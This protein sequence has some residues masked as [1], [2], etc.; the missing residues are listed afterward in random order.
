MTRYTDDDADE[1]RLQAEIDEELA[2][3]GRARAI[4][5]AEIA[6]LTAEQATLG[7]HP[8]HICYLYGGTYASRGMTA[9]NILPLTGFY[10]LPVGEALDRLTSVVTSDGQGDDLLAAVRTVC[11]SDYG[12]ERAGFDWLTDQGL[13]NGKTVDRYWITKPKLG[14][15]QP[16][17]LHGLTRKQHHGHRGLYAL[18]LDD[19]R[20]RFGRAGDGAQ[21]RTYG[22]LMPS[23]IDARARYDEDGRRFAAHQRATDRRDWRGKPPLRAQGFLALRTAAARDLGMPASRTRGDAADWLDGNGANVRFRED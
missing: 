6:R 12:L 8:N 3:L 1:R 4:A 16:A 5:V 21:G 14:L 9:V 11:M 19:L 2:A 22:E 15:G 7:C 18:T 10:R 20:D 13:T 23:I 17:R